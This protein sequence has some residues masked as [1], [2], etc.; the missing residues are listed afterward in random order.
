MDHP[1]RQV[2]VCELLEMPAR[3]LC[4]PPVFVWKIQAKVISEEPRKNRGKAS[5]ALCAFTIGWVQ[6]HPKVCLGD[7]FVYSLPDLWIKFGF[8]NRF[9]ASTVLNLT[10]VLT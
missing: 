8:F 7:A 10:G 2:T 1:S 3:A 6:R 4:K 5:L 9:F